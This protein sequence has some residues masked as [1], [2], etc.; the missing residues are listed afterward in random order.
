[1][2]AEKK[3][4]RA[5]ISKEILDLNSKR[6]VY[7][8]EKRAEMGQENTLDQALIDAVREQGEAQSFLFEKF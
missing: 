3:A 6:E 8:A 4:E 2:I 5:K 1:M 7:V